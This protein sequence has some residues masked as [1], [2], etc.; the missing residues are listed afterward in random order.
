KENLPPQP[1][2]DQLTVQSNLLPLDQLGK[3]S[4]TESAKNALRDW[5]DIDKQKE[6]PA[7]TGKTQP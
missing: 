1:G 3:N 7:C 5:L 2:G 4:D 6:G